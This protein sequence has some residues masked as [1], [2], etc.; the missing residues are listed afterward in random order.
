MPLTKLN[1]SGQPTISHVNLPAGSILQ[2]QLFTL[3]PTAHISTTSATT[4]AQAGNIQ[5]SITP[6]KANSKILI[7]VSTGMGIK[8]TSTL[9]WELY[10]DSTAIITEAGNHNSPYRY[11]W[12]YNYSETGAVYGA[13]SAKSV[14]NAGSTNSRTYKLYHKIATGQS[15]IA[16][17][18]HEGGYISM[19]ATEIAQ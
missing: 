17:T 3:A 2:K 13:T 1:F 7:E 12:L 14:V 10:E 4:S 6:K 11:G 19:F 8:N 18:A 16:Y 15:G 5:I 9:V